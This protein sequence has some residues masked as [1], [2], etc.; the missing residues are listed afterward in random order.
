VFKVCKGDSEKSQV[1]CLR[2]GSGQTSEIEFTI[3]SSLISFIL[4]QLILSCTFKGILVNLITAYSS[5]F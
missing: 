1:G 3:L 2:S 4:L 5:A